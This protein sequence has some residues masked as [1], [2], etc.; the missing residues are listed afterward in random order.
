VVYILV[1]PWLAAAFSDD[2]RVV[3]VLQAYIR[4]TSVGYGMIEVHRYCTFF[5]TGL[6]RPLRSLVLDAVRVIGLLI[7]LSY[8]GALT[9]GVQGAFWGRLI[10]DVTAG[11]VGLLWVVATL[12]RMNREAANTQSS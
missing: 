7:P 10:S 3:R 1:A 12:N 9:V 2:P 4:I 6:H 8:L 5:M 11:G